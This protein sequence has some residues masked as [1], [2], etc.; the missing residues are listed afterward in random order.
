MLESDSNAELA[1]KVRMCHLPVE[2]V[3]RDYVKALV[4]L[5]L[6]KTGPLPLSIAPHESMMLTLQHGRSSHCIEEKL[7]AG[8]NLALTGIRQHTGS[9]NGAGDC[10]TLFALLTP[11]GAVEMLEGRRLEAAPRIRADVGQLL[12]TE[13]VRR[14]E[15]QVAV[16]PQ[17][18]DKLRVF[19]SWLEMRAT[20]N[21]A[22]S[23]GAV[24]AG[25]AASQLCR[26]PNVEIEHLADQQH[27]SRRQLERDFETWIGASPRHLA[28]VARVQE[29]SRHVHRGSSLADAAAA[30]GFADQAHMSRVV[31]QLTGETP[32]RL[33]RSQRTPFAASFRA[34][35]GGT[36]VYL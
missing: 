13:L 2:G 22:Q 26:D 23:R 25:R 35:T 31:R 36:T 1:D 3:L 17:L 14:L 34:V 12:D 7:G 8:R 4:G 6:H 9:F 10:V 19:A 24:R 32:A 18:Q 30:G 5:E 11:I 15:D 27:V 29:V 20:L 21:R 33:I 16:R 28:Q